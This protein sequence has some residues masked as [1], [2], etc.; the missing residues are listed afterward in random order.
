[1]QTPQASLPVGI[2]VRKSP[3]QTRWQ[4]WVWK[5]VAVLPGAR[6]ASWQV[7]RS[8]GPVVEFHAATLPLDLWRTDTEA[9]LSTLSARVPCLGVV[10][11]PDPAGGA[12]E[13]MLVTASA[14]EA[15]DY[16][17]SGEEAVELVPMPEGLVAFIRDFV[18]AHHQEEPFVKR[19]RDRVAMDRKDD[20]IGDPRIQQLTDVYR[21]PGATGRKAVH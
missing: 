9:Y 1:M 21:A 8:E 12:P 15:Q 6:P 18:E 3:G 7:L 20:G 17:D 4:R 19:R 14:Y 2:V 5:A 10:M 11:R 13:L 16:Q